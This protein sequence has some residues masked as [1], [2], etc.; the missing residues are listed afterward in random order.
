[1]FDCTA[2]GRVTTKV[3]VYSFGVI[4]MELITGRKAI[5]ESQ[6][7]ESL[8]LVTWFRRMI[9]NKDKFQ[10]AIDPAMDLNEET[11]ISITKVAQLAGHCTAREPHQRPDMGHTVNV[12]ASLVNV[13]KPSEPEG[14]DDTYGINLDMTLPQALKKWQA[15]GGDESSFFAN[16]GYT[17]SASDNTQSSMP[18][19]PEGLAK[20]FGSSDGR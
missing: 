20:T 5:D 13:W 10:K 16:M 7:E 15:S 8:H 2:T 4:L 11:L 12:L 9:L 3:D 17:P 19:K 6:P 14:S 1:M 18:E